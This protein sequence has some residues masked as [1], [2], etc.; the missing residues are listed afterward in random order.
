VTWHPAIFRPR[1][2]SPGSAVAHIFIIFSKKGGWVGYVGG[3]LKGLGLSGGKG[4]IFA[5][6]FFATNFSEK[7]FYWE[8]CVSRG[9]RPK[10][11]FQ[12]IFQTKAVPVS[13]SM[14]ALPPRPVK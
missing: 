13:G 5:N 14:S 8:Y 1:Q 9:L 6:I 2:I 7:I 11:F 10:R 3:I 4:K 12:K